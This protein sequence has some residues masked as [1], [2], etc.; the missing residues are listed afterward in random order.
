MHCKTCIWW[1]QTISLDGDSPP[2]GGCA[3]SHHGDTA[4]FQVGR[5]HEEDGVFYE[6]EGVNI[7]T[8]HEMFGCVHH[9]EEV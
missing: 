5:V 1:R 2:W 3:L 6:H 9:E 4:L 7:L 8:T